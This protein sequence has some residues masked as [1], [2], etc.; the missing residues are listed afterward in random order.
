MDTAPTKKAI[1]IVED[2]EPIAQLMKDTLNEEPDYQ[3][4]VVHDGSQALEVIQS[5]KASLILLDVNL[6]GIDGL[7]LYDMLREDESTRSITVIFV[8]AS[9]DP[10]EFAARGIEGH[11]AKPFDLGELLSRVAEVCRPGESTE[12]A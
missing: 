7:R 1:V 8:T 9:A 10:A 12:Q 11:I 5:V 2:N 4:V 3:A 6:P